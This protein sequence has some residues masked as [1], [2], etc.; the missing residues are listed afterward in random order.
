MAFAIIPIVFTAFVLIT[1]VS[2]SLFSPV[3]AS[4]IGVC[5]LFFWASVMMR[6]SLIMPAIAMNN[7]KTRLSRSWKLTSGY[8][9]KLLCLLAF[10]NALLGFGQTILEK[11]MGTVITSFESFVVVVVVFGVL[12]IY[13]AMLIAEIQARIFV[14]F[15]VPEKMNEYLKS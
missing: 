9:F 8:Q 1:L 4:V 13:S 15:H 7:S 12:Q 11:L 2:E 10:P 3:L 14:F 6:F 5:F